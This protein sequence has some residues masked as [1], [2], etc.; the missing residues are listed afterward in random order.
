MLLH[1]IL[2]TKLDLIK[3]SYLKNSRKPDF[4]EFA[5]CLDDPWDFV[6][7][8]LITISSKGF[9]A[10]DLRMNAEHIRPQQG[11]IIAK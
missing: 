6:L 2:Q 9:F 10:D 1:F 7:T 5:D 3:S 11:K 8:F 4:P